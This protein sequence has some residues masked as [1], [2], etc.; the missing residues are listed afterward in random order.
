MDW[1]TGIVTYVL[2]WWLALFCV[3]PI[4]AR[5]IEQ[6]DPETG[7]WRGTPAKPQIALKALGTTLLAVVFWLIVYGVMEAGWVDFRDG[8]WAYD[9]PQ[10][11]S[12]VPGI[13]P[14]PR[15]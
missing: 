15:D 6:A 5:P 3:L 7:G 9:G 10:N 12:P 14:R 8:W 11:S 1:F 4:G 2:V 13:S